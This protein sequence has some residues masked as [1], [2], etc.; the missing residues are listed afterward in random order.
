MTY[1]ST[2]CSHLTLTHYV[3]RV[4]SYV[5][6]VTSYVPLVTSY[7]PSH[8]G[9]PSVARSDSVR[10]VLETPSRSRM[11][12]DGEHREDEWIGPTCWA[13]PWRRL[14]WKHQGVWGNP[15]HGTA[16]IPRCPVGMWL[17]GRCDVVTLS[18]KSPTALE[19]ERAGGGGQDRW[20]KWRCSFSLCACYQHSIAVADE[21]K[22]E[23][24]PRPSVTDCP[25]GRCSGQ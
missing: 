25:S 23:F 15:G 4:T 13:N 20:H 10:S 12:S 24:C 14:L 21:S 6:R 1:H 5:P 8:V 16:V 2:R 18:Y 7:V 3:P 17:Y 11:A 9:M 19:R 22:T